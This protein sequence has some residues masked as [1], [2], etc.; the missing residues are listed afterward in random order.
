MR[1]LALLLLLA[2]TSLPALAAGSRTFEFS[3]QLLAGELPTGETVD[4]YLPLPAEHAGQRV[5]AS[6]LQSNL[7]GEIG[8]EERHGN[9]Y[10]RIHRPANINAPVQATLNWTVERSTVTAGSS[11]GAS[12]GELARYLAPNSLVPVGH[13]ILQPILAEIHEQRADD[14]PAATARAIY[15]WV[16]DNMEYK[17]VGSGWGNGDTFWACS[18]RYGNC[19]DFHA[20]FIALARS[21]GIPARFEIGFPVPLERPA[22]DIGG[23]HC[24][25]QFYLPGQG[26][27]PIDA[28]EAA[29]HPEQRELLYG[30]HP[31]DRVH[32]TTG[33]DLVLS[34]GSAAQPLNYFIY[35]YVEVGGKPWR[36]KL[37]TRFSYRELPPG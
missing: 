29:K 7:P 26:W 32:F 18:E 31:A 16:V 33:R 10:Y 27:V 22:G 9:R 36:V 5:V 3:Y 2:L 37:D 25:V 17:K 35:P 8:V 13:E 34:E 19:T 14:S 4:I 23:Y 20:L 1:P 12:E 24:W 15:D 30:T 21:E 28:S 6:S 11:D